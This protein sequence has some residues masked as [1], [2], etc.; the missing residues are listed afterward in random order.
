MSNVQ[1]LSI[2][3]ILA[4]IQIL[5]NFAPAFVE[6]LKKLVDQLKL[7]QES[8]QLT[9]APCCNLDHDATECLDKAISNTADTLLHLVHIK[10][11]ASCPEVPKE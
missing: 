5:G 11:C 3:Q 4:W 9:G 6:M 10:Q 8:G 2:E 1:G 7:K